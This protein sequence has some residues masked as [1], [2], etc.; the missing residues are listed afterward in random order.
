MG[1]SDFTEAESWLIGKMVKAERTL[2]DDFWCDAAVQ[3]LACLAVKLE[4]LLTEKQMATLVGCGALL[5][6]HGKPEMMAKIQ[7]AM[8]FGRVKGRS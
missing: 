1:G 3:E 7:A 6:R 4:P 8:L 5:V 2:P